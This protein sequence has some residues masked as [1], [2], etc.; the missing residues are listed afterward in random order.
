[1]HLAR[2]KASREQRT[3]KALREAFP[4]GIATSAL[5]R[6]MEREER[7]FYKLKDNT[8]LLH[9]G[10]IVTTAPDDGKMGTEMRLCLACGEIFPGNTTAGH[11]DLCKLADEME[12]RRILEIAKTNLKHIDP[13][14][15]IPP[16]DLMES[17]ENLEKM[18]RKTEVKSFKRKEMDR[19]RQN[20]NL[21]A[22]IGSIL[23]T[24]MTQL[25]AHNHCEMGGSIAENATINIDNLFTSLRSA[26]RCLPHREQVHK[27]LRTMNLDREKMN[28]EHMGKLSLRIIKDGN[29]HP[30][31]REGKKK[32]LEDIEAQ[33]QSINKKKYAD[34][35]RKKEKQ[36][37]LNESA[38]KEEEKRNEAA[39]KQKPKKS[40]E[41]DATKPANVSPAKKGREQAK[42]PSSR[43][44]G[45]SFSHIQDSDHFTNQQTKPQPGRVNTNL[46]KDN[47]T[48]IKKLSKGT[49]KDQPNQQRKK[50]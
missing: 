36:D 21:T 9:N 18:G 35:Q 7:N 50:R 20:L 15:I 22:I 14:D 12:H 23:C 39:K 13:Y 19:I 45:I 41:G 24:H 42:S 44:G 4:Q 8:Y 33:K 29:G 48:R 27:T 17:I 3:Q 25:L 10:Y 28:K 43:Q 32:C 37:K 2:E 46:G 30:I 40:S 49:K 26:I 34:E 38:R 31:N 16:Y 1:M 6:A 5:L 47:P 11:Y